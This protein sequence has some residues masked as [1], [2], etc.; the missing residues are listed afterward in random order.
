[1]ANPGP[2][3]RTVV[4]GGI[5]LMV[6][7][8]TFAYSEQQKTVSLW[9]NPMWLYAMAIAV[10]L[11]A[12]GVWEYLAPRNGWWTLP[13][14]SVES[15]P[16]WRLAT[17]ALLPA[18]VGPPVVILLAQTNNLES[19]AVPWTIATVLAVLLY[20]L[21]RR[22]SNQSKLEASRS[23][24]AANARRA[25]TGTQNVESI[26]ARIPQ[27][28]S[29]KER[30]AALGTA[31]REVLVIRYGSVDVNAEVDPQIRAEAIKLL[32]PLLALAE[33][34]VGRGEM[35]NLIRMNS[36][37]DTVRGLYGVADQLS[38][39]AG[40][41]S[42]DTVATQSVEPAND[43]MLEVDLRSA[44]GVVLLANMESPKLWVNP[45]ITSFA[46]YPLRVTHLTARVNFGQL[47][48]KL[49]LDQPYVIP[50][51]STRSDVGLSDTPDSDKV[52]KIKEF[53]AGGNIPRKTL[54]VY[55][56]ITA[57]SQGGPIE[58][59]VPIERNEPELRTIIR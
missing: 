38:I 55:I 23:L 44:G 52:A 56:A 1:M 40:K 28:A 14:P 25:G 22:N 17:V 39:L 24:V 2:D 48:L 16:W 3:S 59:F 33:Q 47:E 5:S 57:E 54:Y 19:P 53:L 26:V 4:V 12:F 36:I 13:S 58:K 42:N 49:A 7:L 50:A 51:L 9:L 35:V 32:D 15:R 30:L 21:I 18:L 46:P 11:I 31:I 27:D 37:F 34:D 43:E 41:M 10:V 29:P 45:R 6:L 8:V 20:G